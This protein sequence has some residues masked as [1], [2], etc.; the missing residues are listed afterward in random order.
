MLVLRL[1]GLLLMA[2]AFV[3]FIVDG[4]KTIA[5]NAIEITPFGEAWAEIYPASLDALKS[6]VE[7]SGYPVLWDPLLLSILT[8]PSWLILV[9]F[10]LFFQWLGRR[11]EAPSIIVNER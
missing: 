11:R 1:F 10:G 8:A 3:A 4:V 5:S 2:A 6:L 9:F 7:G